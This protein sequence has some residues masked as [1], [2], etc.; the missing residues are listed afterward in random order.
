MNVTVIALG[1]LL[2]VLIYVLYL[3]LSP[4]YSSLITSASL[5]TNTPPLTGI[6]SPTSP[7]YAYGLWLYVN[8]WNNTSTNKYIFTRN[9]N[10]QLYLDKTQLNLYLD[11]YMNTGSGSGAWLST[12]TAPIL[13]TNNYPIQK[14]CYIVVSVD[15][16]FIDCYLDGKLIL[17][18]KTYMPNPISGSSTTNIYPAMP[19]DIGQSSSV[20][21]GNSYGSG[22]NIILGGTDSGGV[23]QPMYTNFDAAINKFMRWST[24]V[25]PQIVWDTYIAGN[26]SNMNLMSSFSSYNAKLDILKNQA[27]YTSFSLF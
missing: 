19:P 15:S 11:V 26:G 9:N 2:L 1:I 21:S 23:S 24:P 18:Q 22:A 12:I 5:L 4:S 20:N 13:I 25:N 27:A 10:I 17:S 8:S 6:E 7:R 14:W 3:Y 16:A